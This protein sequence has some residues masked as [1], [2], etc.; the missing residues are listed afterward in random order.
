MADGR[1][2][3]PHICPHAVPGAHTRDVRGTACSVVPQ[4][5]LSILWSLDLA[6]PEPL[7]AWRRTAK[8]TFL[9]QRYVAPRERAVEVHWPP[10]TTSQIL[11]CIAIAHGPSVRKGC[12]KRAVRGRSRLERPQNK[13]VDERYFTSGRRAHGSPTP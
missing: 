11:F 10:T 3:R 12:C 9:R 4:R 2:V 6:C 13:E 8:I 7:Q 5:T 1:A